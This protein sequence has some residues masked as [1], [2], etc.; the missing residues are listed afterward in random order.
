M[1]N[2][3]F[4]NLSLYIIIFLTILFILTAI[5]LTSPPANDVPYTYAELLRDLRLGRI[6]DL[7]IT[8]DTDVSNAGVAVATLPDGS[9][10]TVAIPSVELFMQIVHPAF[11]DYGFA[12]DTNAAPK[13]GW[14]M[15]LLPSL[16]ILA[17]SVLLL[18]FIL[19]Q[20]QGGSGGGGG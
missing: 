10:H 17:V 15:Q 3:L 13:P 6:A 20:V 2:K 1:N 11:D 5:R 14:F 16:L 7:Q 8:P 18:L 12:L 19:Q 9:K 4:K